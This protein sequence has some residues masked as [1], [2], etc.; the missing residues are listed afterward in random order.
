MSFPILKYIPNFTLDRSCVIHH[1]ILSSMWISDEDLIVAKEVAAKYG[2]DSSVVRLSTV[3]FRHLVAENPDCSVLQTTFTMAEQV[4]LEKLDG[5]IRVVVEQHFKTKKKIHLRMYFAFCCWLEHEWREFQG[6]QL[7]PDQCL[8]MVYRSWEEKEICQNPL[9][10]ILSMY[11][12][13]C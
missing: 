5:N 6:T 8:A 7:N 13:C 1:D 9:F 3:L 12:Y 4:D 10:E 2:Y 11:A